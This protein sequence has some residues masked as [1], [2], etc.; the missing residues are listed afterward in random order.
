MSIHSHAT[1]IEPISQKRYHANSPESA[2]VHPRRRMAFD[3]EVL[4][5]LR[6]RVARSRD[7][8]PVLEGMFRRC[9]AFHVQGRR[10][11]PVPRASPRILCIPAT[12]TVPVQACSLQFR[13]QLFTSGPYTDAKLAAIQPDR[14]TRVDCH[15]ARWVRTLAGIDQPAVV[16][17]AATVGMRALLRAVGRSPRA[18]WTMVGIAAPIA[19]G[20]VREHFDAAPPQQ[21]TVVL[22]AES[23]ECHG[24]KNRSNSRFRCVEILVPHRSG[25]DRREPRVVGHSDRPEMRTTVRKGQQVS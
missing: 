7:R 3:V 19:G 10:R 13:Q 6:A 1:G 9:R 21:T 25:S 17:R 14:R 12:A 5:D 18:T 2:A 24:R 15:D 4:R 11:A 16:D 22:P 23:R 8:K 20:I